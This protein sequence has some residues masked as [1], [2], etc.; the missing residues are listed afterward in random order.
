MANI[1]ISRFIV[2]TS[3]HLCFINVKTLDVKIWGF[4]R[5]GRDMSGLALQGFS[6]KH[7]HSR[8]MQGK[9]PC[10]CDLEQLF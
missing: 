5:T 1:Y 8:L 10:P 3:K 2:L 6:S 4:D 9:T 7:D